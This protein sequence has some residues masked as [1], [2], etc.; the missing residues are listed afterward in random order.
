MRSSRPH[1]IQIFWDTSSNPVR[2]RHW[3]SVIFLCDITLQCFCYLTN[4]VLLGTG[5]GQWIAARDVLKR[6]RITAR[7]FQFC[8]AKQLLNRGASA[9]VIGTK[10]STLTRISRSG[11]SKPHAARKHQHH[12]IVASSILNDDAHVSQTSALVVGNTN[13]A[14]CPFARLLQAHRLLGEGAEIFWHPG[15]GGLATACCNFAVSCPQALFNWHMSSI[16]KENIFHADNY[17]SI[18]IS[19]CSIF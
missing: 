9:K 14:L 10:S 16:T 11:R 4:H 19:R 6:R 2:Q 17:F 8:I 12:D 13:V 1:S 7:L 18:S 5:I 15:L 3:T